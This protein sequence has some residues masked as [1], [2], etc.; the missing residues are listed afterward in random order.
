MNKDLKIRISSD[1]ANNI[2][3]TASVKIIVIRYFFLTVGPSFSELQFEELFLL[4]L[5]SWY[6]HSSWGTVVM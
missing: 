2:P 5:Q 6:F 4:H 3:I 1:I